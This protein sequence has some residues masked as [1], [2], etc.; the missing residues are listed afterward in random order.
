MAYPNWRI[1]LEK[2]PRPCDR[3]LL[4]YEGRPALVCLGMALRRSDGGNSRKIRFSRDRSYEPAAPGGYVGLCLQEHTGR[5]RASSDCDCSDGAG[6]G[7]EHHT[8][9][10]ATTSCDPA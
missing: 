6:N 8:L 5:I 10:C 1:D 3:Y 4:I 7:G 2:R 9:A